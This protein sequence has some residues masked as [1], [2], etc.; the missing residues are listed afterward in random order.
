MGESSRQAAAPQGDPGPV[1]KA[2]RP[3]FKRT[4]T[5]FGFFAITA[6]MVMTVYEYPSFASSGFPLVFFLIIGG[7]CGSCPS[8]CARPRWQ[9]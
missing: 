3:A 7:F 9:R 2:G 1:G 5:F 4:L 6:S 8:R